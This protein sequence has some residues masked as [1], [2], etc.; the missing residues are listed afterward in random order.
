MEHV[1][2]YTFLL[3]FVVSSKGVLSFF[4][5]SAYIHWMGNDNVS[6]NV[7]RISRLLI[8]RRIDP[9]SLQLSV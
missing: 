3:I 1:H 6:F 4:P 2:A 5:T 8:N 7:C 9:L